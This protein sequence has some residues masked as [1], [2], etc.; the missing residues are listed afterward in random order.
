MTKFAA[1][2]YNIHFGSN[3]ACQVKAPN[4][5][6]CAYNLPQQIEHMRRQQ[7]D[8]I[9][10]QEV[11]VGTKRPQAERPV[12]WREG[13]QAAL[14]ANELGM[15][16]H[17]APGL[18]ELYGGTS[19]CAVLSRYDLYN[20]WSY[21]YLRSG[22]QS[23]VMVVATVSGL[24]SGP[25]IVISTHLGGTLV[26]KRD[27]MEQLVAQL[28]SRYFPTLENADFLLGG[29]FNA[30]AVTSPE[31]DPL[32]GF[33]QSTD[34]LAHGLEHRIGGIDQLW[35]RTN[36]N[37]VCTSFRNVQ[38]GESF[39]VPEEPWISD[40]TMTRSDFVSTR[41]LEQMIGCLQWLGNPLGR[42]PR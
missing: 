8:I 17:Y 29:D 24:S 26:Q 2:T 23:G 6:K 25:L 5:S 40:H 16:W 3:A 4:P 28:K 32:K 38:D 10:L 33:F 31:L 34:I 9:F 1:A 20:K 13:D 37:L 22:T 15:R 27:K 14:I 12:D 35:L 42:K 36:G 18:D 41:D 39:S 11:D 7:L 19:G 30:D 21:R